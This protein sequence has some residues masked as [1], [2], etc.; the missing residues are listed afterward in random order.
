MNRR[1]CVPFSVPHMNGTKICGDT[2]QDDL[3]YLRKEMFLGELRREIYDSMEKVDDSYVNDPIDKEDD[4]D[5]KNKEYEEYDGSKLEWFVPKNFF[6]D[7]IEK[8]DKSDTKNEE[9]EEYIDLL[10]PCE[11]LP[12]CSSIDYDTE[13]SHSSLDYNQYSKLKASALSAIPSDALKFVPH[14]KNNTFNDFVFLFLQNCL[15]V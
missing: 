6:G 3:A 11:C 13:I 12:S 14:R 15:L 4:I 5:T 10:S 7:L 8:E 9:Y 2:D 1:Q